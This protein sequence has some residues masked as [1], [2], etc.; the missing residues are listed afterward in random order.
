MGTDFRIS[1]LISFL[2]VPGRKELRQTQKRQKGGGGIQ[3]VALSLARA[4][5]L[6]ANP[7]LSLHVV[8]ELVGIFFFLR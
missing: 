1:R 3:E 8:A 4:K 5:Q 6:S 7:A 2:L